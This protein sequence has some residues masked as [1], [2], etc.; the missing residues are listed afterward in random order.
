M[1]DVTIPTKEQL[2]VALR[3]AG[4]VALAERAHA[5]EFDDFASDVHELPKIALAYELEQLGSTAA[6]VFR[7]RV[8]AGEFD[9]TLEEADA[10]FAREGRQLIE[11][12]GQ[13]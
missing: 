13:E 10:W 12:A 5:G 11:E 3:A 2:A 9:N 1:S 4:F 6:H 8:I 7:G